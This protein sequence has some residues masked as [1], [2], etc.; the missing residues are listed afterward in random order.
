MLNIISPEELQREVGK[1]GL[2]NL[3]KLGYWLKIE[4]NHIPA[5]EN[6]FEGQR[7]H[8]NISEFFLLPP[9]LGPSIVCESEVGLFGRSIPRFAIR[10]E[11]KNSPGFVNVRRLATLAGQLSQDLQIET[12]LIQMILSAS[13]VADAYLA[14]PIWS[15]KGW[16]IL[17]APLGKACGEIN[18]GEADKNFTPYV[19][20]IEPGGGMCAQAACFMATALHA[21]LAPPIHGLPEITTIATGKTEILN[22]TIEFD[23]LY[24]HE[25]SGYFN[26]K[27]YCKTIGA[28]WQAAKFLYDDKDSSS[29]K[30]KHSNITLEFERALYSYLCSKMPIIVPVDVGRLQGIGNG[31]YIEDKRTKIGENTL[32][33]DLNDPLNE[34]RYDHS[35]FIRNGLIRYLKEEK[36]EQNRPHVV[37]VIGCSGTENLWSSDERQTHHTDSSTPSGLFCFHDPAHL[38]FMRATAH[39]LLVAGCYQEGAESLKPAFK[40]I[41]LGWFLPVVPSAVQMPLLDEAEG[42][43]AGIE[44]ISDLFH[45]IGFK[46]G[47][48]VFIKRIF[49]IPGR[50]RPN[51][52]L[53]KANVFD[54]LEH[55]KS[56]FGVMDPEQEPLIRHSFLEQLTD[57]KIEKWCWLQF[58]GTEILLWDAEK[59]LLKSELTD[60][61]ALFYQTSRGDAKDKNELIDRVSKLASDL[62]VAATVMDSNGHF[63]R[64]ST[65]Q[66]PGAPAEKKRIGRC[67]GSL[68]YSLLT[69]FET[70][71]DWKPFLRSEEN[72]PVELYMF[73][74]A[75]ADKHLSNFDE[76]VL[77]NLA[78]A[79]HNSRRILG[80]DRIPRIWRRTCALELMARESRNIYLIEKTAREI[81][82]SGRQTIALAS[83]LPS[84]SAGIY[85]TDGK[86]SNKA[87]L[88]TEFVLKVA[89]ALKLKFKKNFPQVIQLIGGSRI[90]SRIDSSPH[91]KHSVHCID[92]DLAILNI[93]SCLEKLLP[94]AQSADVKLAF[95][96]EHSVHGALGSL[97]NVELF[98]ENLA[99]RSQHDNLWNR[100]GI[101]LDIGQCAFL[102]KYHPEQFSHN[103]LD[104]II[105]AHINSLGRGRLADCPL[106]DEYTHKSSLHKREEFVVWLDFLEKIKRDR[107]F[108]GFVTLELECS[109]SE[110]MIKDSLA[111]LK[112]WFYD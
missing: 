14:P 63:K 100:V 66:P 96:F 25:I 42:N 37:L 75:Y 64:H 10:L 46:F 59:C 8:A 67:S 16:H 112:N 93:L 79:F 3:A 104:R 111:K 90:V 54:I 51:F 70:V 74:Q 58:N 34:W 40:T 47:E 95:E 86:T 41:S 15:K 48:D 33:V 61:D 91:G 108:L 36:A 11:L 83:Y 88:A 97:E 92:H 39:E 68:S 87:L 106:E 22:S 2:F 53:V 23:G 9:R 103:L 98:C 72:V 19:K 94:L 21:S 24:T 30:N 69:S 77:K 99:D 35:I 38:P 109:K 12:R 110:K 49:A 89:G 102:G 78:T 26:S 4:D 107:N 13:C 73:M 55:V 17:I 71:K 31:A 82:N 101:N 76:K 50:R 18:S 5:W 43:K 85:S 62:L 28:S 1:F 27:K 20:H 29:L 56:I 81:V 60:L 44:S 45:E 6:E 84:L 105:H 57:L 32:S 65:F 52:R 80:K 7:P